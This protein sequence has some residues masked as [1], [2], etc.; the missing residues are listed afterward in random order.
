MIKPNNGIRK[1]TRVHCAFK[2]SRK[3]SRA[4][5]NEGGGPQTHQFGWPTSMHSLIPRAKARPHL[6]A[7]PTHLNP[8][9]NPTQP[10]TS[11]SRHVAHGLH[12]CRAVHPIGPHSP[13]WPWPSL[14]AADRHMS[15]QD[16]HC[17]RWFTS[18]PH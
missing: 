6:V 1:S 7:G 4:S 8:H 2:P 18:P 11:I 17:F 5:S 12:T 15:S 9:A 10:G 3:P 16:H 13:T 14:S